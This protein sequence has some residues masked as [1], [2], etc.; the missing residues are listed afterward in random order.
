MNVLILGGGLAGLSAATLLT[1]FG[2]TVTTLT[3]E[4]GGSLSTVTVANP[5][6][7]GVFR[8]D[9]GAKAYAKDGA[10]HQLIRGVEGVVDHNLTS[11]YMNVVEPGEKVLQPFRLTR[12]TERVLDYESG[13]NMRAAC[14]QL[15]GTGFYHEFFEPFYERQLSHNPELLDADWMLTPEFFE[16][17]A[18][19]VP[20]GHVTRTM[21]ASLMEY[22]AEAWSWVNGN[23]ESLYQT[24]QG[25][26]VIGRS[27]GSVLTLGPFDAVI[28]T[29]GIAEL[30][31][32]LQRVHGVNMPMSPWNNLICCGV[33]LPEEYNGRQFSWLY[34]D[35]DH[36]RAH[37][38]S[39]QSS[40]H[41]SM[42][43]D[44]HDSLLFEFPT[45]D[46]LD[47]NLMES[48][49][50]DVD[51]I[52]GYLGLSSNEVVWYAGKGYAIPTLN[53][54]T[55]IAETKRQ[56]ARHKVYS[57]G[58]WGSHVNFSADQILGE[59]L[60]C[61]NLIMSGEEEHEYLWSTDFYK[62]YERDNHATSY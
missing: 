9:F 41:P 5:Y 19:Y 3:P 30:V 23:A 54:R 35:V 56:L 34:P 25:W 39:L 53:T 43:P 18:V 46:E 36:F 42:A 51:S 61:V 48:Y 17:P 47:Q 45:F 6:G 21:V 8:F 58:Q 20:G 11:Y 49:A 27:G 52:L 38:V 33:C 13:T 37:R 7:E 1:R 60:R 44:G 12:E 26:N 4:F 15:Y 22:N 59:A 40:M 10:F 29:I 28:S 31:A 62:V 2:V 55:D 24:R 16:G 14:Q 57:I 32:G 50:L